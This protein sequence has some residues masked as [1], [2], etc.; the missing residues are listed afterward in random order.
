MNILIDLGHPAHVH[1]FHH[2]IR[3]WESKGYNC[4]IVARNKDVT[5]RLLK[6]YGLPYIILAPISHS[7][8][9]QARE[10]LQREMKM[11]SLAKKFRPTI[12]TGTSV[13]AARVAKFVGAKSV[14]LNEDDARAVPLFR[15]LAYPLASAIITPDCL[16]HENYGARHLTYPSYHELFYLHPNHFTLD[17]SIR[18]KIGLN[19]N[20]K[21]AIIRLSALQAHHDINI[22]G[23]SEELIRKLIHLVNNEIKIFI[24]AE[25]PLSSEFEHFRYSIEPEHM[26]NILGMAEF[27]L[28]DSQTMTAEAAILGIPA[29]RINNFVGRISYLKDLENYGLAFGFK[30]GEENLLLK[31]LNNV[32]TMDNR[33]R[34]FQSRHQDMLAKK[35]DPVP[36][37]IGVIDMLGARNPLKNKKI[38][39]NKG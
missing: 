20:E 11:L 13:H 25:K 6:N 36:W 1:L 19:E 9:D 38:S 2:A 27:F 10:L 31:S 30:P 17:K 18:K 12:I 16:A 21:F 7:P 8:L 39:R 14:I 34:I 5:L 26:H 33:K 29:F 23:I 15:W 24:T 32:L 37:L 22:K 28:G 3:A 35:I 4:K